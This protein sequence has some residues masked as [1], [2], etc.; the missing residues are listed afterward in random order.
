MLIIILC[1]YYTQVARKELRDFIQWT[2]YAR[3][4]VILFYSLCLVEVC[5]SNTYFVRCGGFAGSN[6]DGF[7]IAF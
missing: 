2:V 6:L 3:S 5:Q 7:D 1:F 4:A